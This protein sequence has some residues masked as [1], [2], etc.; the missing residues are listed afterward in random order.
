MTSFWEILTP[1]SEAQN[2]F[3][4]CHPELY[5]R[6]ASLLKDEI[7]RFAQNDKE[8]I[9]CRMTEKKIR[10]SRLHTTEPQDDFLYCHPE[11]YLRRVSP[12]KFGVSLKRVFYP[13]N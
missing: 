4:Y 8:G 2:D 6:R 10:S 3:L 1:L 7:L 13:F 9:E 5:L 12:F 11:L